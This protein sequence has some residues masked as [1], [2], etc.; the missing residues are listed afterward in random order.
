MCHRELSAHVH[1]TRRNQLKVL[2]IVLVAVFANHTVAEEAQTDELKPFQRQSESVVRVMSWN[3]KIDS[4]FP[5]D[6]VRQESFIRIVRALEPDVIGL[7]EVFLGRTDALTALMNS[8][9]PLSEG[10]FWSVHMVGDNALISR[11]P[12]EQLGGELVVPFP[13]PQLGVPDFHYGFAAAY[14]DLPES[15]S[16]RDLYVITMHNK[17]RTGD[18]NVRLRQVQ[19]DATVRWLRNLRVEG[20]S[21]SIP[22]FTPIVVM[23][24]LNVVPG[25]S[26]RPY[27]TLITGDIADEETFGPDVELDW[28]GTG[29]VDSMPSVNGGEEFYYTWRNDEVDFPPSSLDRILFTDSV[30]SIDQKFVLDTTTM[31]ESVLSA[32]GMQRSDVLYGG[33]IGTYDHLPLFTDFVVHKVPKNR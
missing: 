27:E 14:I 15:T 1:S 21:E 20:R 17:S 3:I 23:G 31:S 24:D 32:L 26:M 16:D 19:S 7:Q 10:R 11:Y 12:L 18:E 22:I 9:I 2:L 5:P 29:L 28:D 30:M 4:I 13:Y 8:Y 25:A 6:G 33:N